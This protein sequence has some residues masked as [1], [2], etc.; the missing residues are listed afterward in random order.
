MARQAVPVQTGDVID[1]LNSGEAVIKAGD[2][3]SAGYICGVAVTD[4][5]PKETG[6]LSITGVYSIKKEA[7]VTLALGD[8]VCIKEGKIQKHADGDSPCGIAVA[9]AAAQDAAALVKINI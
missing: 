2:L 4:I 3:V 9:A 1:Y 6:A 8:R 5:A 7:S